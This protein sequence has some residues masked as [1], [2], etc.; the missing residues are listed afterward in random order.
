MA[1]DLKTTEKKLQDMVKAASGQTAAL[2]RRMDERNARVAQLEQRV[3]SQKAM[4]MKAVAKPTKIAIDL[5]GGVLAQVST[6][7]FNWIVRKGGKWSK[8]GFL[9]HNVDLL[10][11]LPHLLLGSLAYVAEMAT[12]KTEKGGEPQFPSPTRQTLSEFAKIFAQLGFS[13]L[14]RAVRTRMK[15]ASETVTENDALR[16]ENEAVRSKLKEAEDRLSAAESKK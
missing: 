13:N 15:D 7:T 12:R 2:E 1:D 16:A 4:A 3:A 14:T 11:G 5:G 10:Q 9:A 6:E 8:D